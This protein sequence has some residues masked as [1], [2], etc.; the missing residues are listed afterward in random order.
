MKKQERVERGRNQN[1]PS[2]L[3]TQY[4]KI[5]AL[6]F[7]QLPIICICVHE[8]EPLFLFQIVILF[9]NCFRIEQD[10]TGRTYAIDAHRLNALV[11]HPPHEENNN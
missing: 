9:E 4:T 2:R 3:E 8:S 6:I 11:P 1:I 5:H 7:G 10:Y